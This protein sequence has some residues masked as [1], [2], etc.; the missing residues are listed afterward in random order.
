MKKT[1]ESPGF[2]PALERLLR[3]TPVPSHCSAYA[4]LILLHGLFSVNAHLKARDSATLGVGPMSSSADTTVATG[5]VE[6]WKDTLERA[7][8]T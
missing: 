7:K 1:P 3:R 8:E 2:L 6:T 5:P 4:R